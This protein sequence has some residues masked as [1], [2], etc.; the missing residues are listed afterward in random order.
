MKVRLALESDEDAV[1][2]MARQ[3]TVQTRPELAFSEARCRKSFQSYLTT[4]SP[5]IFVAD[6]R[7]E[8]VGMLVC[9]F[10][11]YRAADGLCVAQEVLFVRP[12]KRGTRAAALLMKELIAWAELLGAQE[13][14]GGNDNAF[15]SDRTARFLEHFGFKRVGFSMRRGV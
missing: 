7:G 4:A 10:F 9:D 11:E 12:D 13:I 2:G 15:N 14:V 3:N 1:V 8:A 6:D 5:T